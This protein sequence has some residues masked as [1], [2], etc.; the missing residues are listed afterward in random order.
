MIQI[1]WMSLNIAV[2]PHFTPWPYSTNYYL[3]ETIVAVVNG[4]QGTNQKAQ[5]HQIHRKSNRIQ[6]SSLSFAFI[7]PLP[8]VSL[9]LQVSLYW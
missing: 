6:L 3:Y 2:V 4:K 9:R 1:E 8:Y 7:F 5:N